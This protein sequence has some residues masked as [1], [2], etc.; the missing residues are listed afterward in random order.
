V[1]EL[2]YLWSFFG[3]RSPRQNKHHARTGLI[4]AL[5][6]EGLSSGALRDVEKELETE[7]PPTYLGGGFR[8]V[9]AEDYMDLVSPCSLL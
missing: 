2:V 8:S 5:P 6:K 9:E 1:P 4:Q 7:N 3:I